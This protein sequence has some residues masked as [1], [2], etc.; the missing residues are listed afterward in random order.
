MKKG[1]AAAT[2]RPLIRNNERKAIFPLTWFA[3]GQSRVEEVWF[4]GSHTDV[5]GGYAKRGLADRSLE[6]MI[7][8]A[9][10]HGLPIKT[11]P[12]DGDVADHAVAFNDSSMGLTKNRIARENDIFHWSVQAERDRFENIE[13]LLPSANAIA[14]SPRPNAHMM[15]A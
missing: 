6:W 5:G 8:E 10:A 13:P 11:T 9:N 14:Y 7:E 4:L 12:I 2:A 1:R 15:I 3:P